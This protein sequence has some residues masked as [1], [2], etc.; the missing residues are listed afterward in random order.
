V[1]K[2]EYSQSEERSQT[3]SLFTSIWGFGLSNT[4]K[5]FK[6]GMRSVTDLQ[7]NMHLLSVNQK[8]GLKYFDDSQKRIPYDETTEIYNVI[9]KYLHEVMPEDIIESIVCGSYRRQQPDSGIIDI[10]ITR[11]DDGKVEGILESLLEKLKNI[12]LIRETLT[13]SKNF[14]CK[15]QFNGICK[16]KE[17][18][19]FRR[20]DI[21]VINTKTYKHKYLN[22]L[23]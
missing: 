12:G 10:L 3:I 5:L 7:N 17:S 13:F 4:N 19:P 1:S 11:K 16:L 18:L 20:L 23:G 14:K 15:N 6:M 9:N 22:K 21:K 2:S 8:I